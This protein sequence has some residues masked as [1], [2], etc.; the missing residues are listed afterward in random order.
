MALNPS[1]P[2]ADRTEVSVGQAVRPFPGEPLCGDQSGWWRHP[3]R[4]RLALADGLGHGQEAHAAAATVVEHLATMRP[5]GLAELFADCDR[6][7]IGSRGAALAVVD[8]LFEENALLHAAVGNVRTLLIGQRQIR[9]LPGARG[10]VGGGFSGLRP[11]R[12]PLSAGDW[13]VIFSDG[14]PE[15]A[16]IRASLTASR[17]SDALAEQ[18][19]ERWARDQ[20][21]AGILIYR[22]E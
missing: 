17:S 10:I 3:D 12:L 21:D 13:L 18:L 2:T 20:D 9:R 5:T 6:T 15:D 19:L 1:S 22:H 16:D 4:L 8:V 7:L 11:E 14:I